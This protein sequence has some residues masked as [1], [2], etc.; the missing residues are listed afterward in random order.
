M[1]LFY[2]PLTHDGVSAIRALMSVPVVK[3]KG[4]I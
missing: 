3:V 4:S 1:H 2:F